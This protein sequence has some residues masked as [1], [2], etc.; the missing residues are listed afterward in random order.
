MSSGTASKTDE[1]Y[2]ERHVYTKHRAGLPPLRQ[3][4]KE[5]W[6]RRQF[7]L[8]LAR[9]DQRSSHADTT[10][11]KIWMVL[12]PLLLGCVYFVLVDVIA[13]SHQGFG[14]FTHLLAG[15]FLFYLVQNCVIGGAQSVTAGA[16]LVL[17]TPFPRIL[18]PAATAYQALIRFWPT[19]IV[20]GV[21]RTVS[22]IQK[23]PVWTC[24]VPLI[25]DRCPIPAKNL[26]YNAQFPINWTLILAIPIIFIVLMFA[27]GLGAFFATLQVYFRDTASFL[28]YFTR[29]WMYLSPVI[30]TSVLIH[31]KLGKLSNLN[32][33]YPMFSAWDWVIEWGRVPPLQNW[34]FSLAWMVVALVIGSWYL[35]SRERDFAV[36]L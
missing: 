29:I 18:M 5:A 33:L 4:F 27:F 6:R 1:L 9:T 12:N 24:K 36:R 8:E 25:S 21:I 17:N 32:P 35:M 26:V 11:G 16:R 23:I 13:G 2:G 20:L 31:N 30:L 3:Y 22:T 34:L 14:Y 19:L 15:L 7:P 10:L 28:P